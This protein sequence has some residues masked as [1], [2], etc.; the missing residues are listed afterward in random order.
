MAKKKAPD[1]VAR[2][3]LDGE[4]LEI[5]FDSLTFGEAEEVEVYFNC[6][7]GEVDWTSARANLFLC[8]LA[9]KRKDT[10]ASLDDVRDL[11]VSSLKEAKPRPT[12]SGGESGGGQS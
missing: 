9:K 1:T 2:F 10:N 7:L 6:G 5:D 3:E 4:V 8:Y 11:P 12:K